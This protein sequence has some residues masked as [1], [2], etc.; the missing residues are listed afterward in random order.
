MRRRRRL[1][2]SQLAEHLA[3]LPTDQA[4]PELAAEDGGIE[5]RGALAETGVAVL[6]RHPDH[7]SADARH[8]TRRHEVGRLEG[9]VRRPCL[10]ARDAAHRAILH[11]R[12]TTDPEWET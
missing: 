6:G 7:C 11:V 9:D 3:R 8:D 2:H 10:H 1:D 12:A 4:L 5:G